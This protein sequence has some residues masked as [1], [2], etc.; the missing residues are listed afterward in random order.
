VTKL[1]QVKG[2]RLVK[3][4]RKIGWY[5]DH[6]QGSH[7]IMRHNDK[8]GAVAVIPIHAR[9]IKPGTLHNILK[10]VNLSIEE[11]KGLL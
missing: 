2:D 10:T 6:S 1:P 5:I 3:A 7:V 4:L 8:L 11:L 9:P